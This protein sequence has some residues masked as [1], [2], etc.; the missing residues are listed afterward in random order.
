MARGAFLCLDSLGSSEGVGFA[1]Q[2]SAPGRG[3][4][5]REV[6]RSAST[7]RCSPRTAAR[8]SPAPTSVGLL[9]LGGP[10][11]LGYYK[12][13]EKIGGHVPDVR[14]QALLDPRRLGEGRG[15]RHDRAARPGQRVDQ[16]GRREDLPRGGRGGGEAAPGRA[17]T[18]SSSA[19]P[20]RSSARRSPRSCRSGP[21]SRR[22]PTRSST[23]VHGQPLGVQGAASRGRRRRGAPAARTARP[24]TPGRSRSPPSTS[25][26]GAPARRRRAR[27][28]ARRRVLLGLR[29]EVRAAAEDT[30]TT[31]AAAADARPAGP[32]GAGSADRSPAATASTSRP[33]APAPAVPTSGWVE[34]EY[35][36]SGTATS[37][38]VRRT[39][40][41]RRPLPAHRGTDG[42]VPHPHR[43]APAPPPG[44]VQRHG[45]SSSGST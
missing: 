25:R 27:R 6:L 41:H 31:R 19:C 44:R 21:A 33:R 14:R 34:A 24:T 18:R 9:A 11:P 13:P 2:I 36:A 1:Q 22:P 45:R 29:R 7:P 37:Y 15:R 35:S 38:R 17:R 42:R 23:T 4:D 8:S 16:L 28:G 12:D 10:I 43:G 26:E 32:R 20:T 30:T 3:G 39:A 5:D 40:A